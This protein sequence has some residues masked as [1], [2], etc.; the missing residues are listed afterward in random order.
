MQEAGDGRQ[1]TESKAV[2]E[3]RTPRRH[4]CGQSR[5]A[6]A[7]T[8]GAP[9]FGGEGEDQLLGGPGDANDDA[10]APALVAALQRLAH[11]LGAAD[12]AGVVL[13]RIVADQ[14]HGH[15]GR[16]RQQELQAPDTVGHDAAKDVRRGLLDLVGEGLDGVGAPE[17]VDHVGDPALV[18]E[19]VRFTYADFVLCDG[20]PLADIRNT[21]AIDQVMVRGLLFS[22]DSIRKAW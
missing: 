7:V 4:R 11:Q 1:V 17:R 12:A 13:D 8:V 22:A 16:R 18:R 14:P 6:V 5:G 21:L 9:V 2:G 19:D 20:D 10:D 3:T 15:V